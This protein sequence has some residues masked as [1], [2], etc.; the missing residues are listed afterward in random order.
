MDDKLDD[1]L[2]EIYK[3]IKK[4]DDFQMKLKLSIPFIS[5]L[6]IKFETEFDVKNWTKKMYEKYKSEI[7]QLMSAL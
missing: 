5:L 1:K 4:T 3:D 6:G 2:K 7:F